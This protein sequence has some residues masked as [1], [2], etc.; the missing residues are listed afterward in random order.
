MPSGAT[1]MGSW[2]LLRR[3]DRNISCSSALSNSVLSGDAVFGVLSTRFNRSTV[4]IFK[5]PT[6][7]NDATTSTV[8][9][10]AEP[11]LIK[12]PAT[13]A[14][15]GNHLFVSLDDDHPPHEGGHHP[16]EHPTLTFFGTYTTP[17]Q[18]GGKYDHSRSLS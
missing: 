7:R 18:S 12:A 3:I 13:A 11:K 14:S 6:Q 2:V 1:F 10:M 9:D 17:A 8:S 16:H 15:E 5:H 4:Y